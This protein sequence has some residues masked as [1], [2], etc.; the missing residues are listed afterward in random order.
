M[1]RII[2]ISDQEKKSESIFLAILVNRPDFGPLQL[3]TQFTEKNWTPI[4]TDQSVI[5][6]LDHYYYSL[7]PH[8]SEKMKL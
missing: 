5:L 6:T 3:L 1:T 8:R 2:K 7:I 4:M